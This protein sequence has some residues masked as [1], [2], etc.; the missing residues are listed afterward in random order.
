[1]NNSNKLKE[2]IIE[3]SRTKNN[4]NKDLALYKEIME[5]CEKVENSDRIK[6]K[7]KEVFAARYSK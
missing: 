7:T 5:L 2:R 6:K 3:F 4:Y 1:M